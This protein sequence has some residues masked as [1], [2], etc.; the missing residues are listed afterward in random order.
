MHRSRRAPITAL[1]G[2]LALAGLAAAAGLPTYTLRLHRGKGDKATYEFTSVSTDQITG[3]GAPAGAI[4]SKAQLACAI[5]FQGASPGG[6]I[7]IQAKVKEGLVKGAVGGQS[8]TIPVKT[9]LATYVLTPRSELKQSELTTGSPP[10]ISATGTVFTA[11]DAFLPPPLPDK[12]VRVGDRWQSSARIPAPSGDPADARDVKY[13]SRVLGEMTYAGRSCLKIRTAF[14]QSQHG[15]VKAP[16]GSGSVAVA[17]QSKG[18]TT[19]VFDPKAG[20]VMKS[21]ATGTMTITRVAKTAGQQQLLKV[22]STIRTHAKM[23]EYN[24]KKIAAQ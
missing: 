5:E 1:L 4:T 18:E 8:Q 2:A 19:W 6:R 21:D 16:D 24:G 22:S 17:V 23:T 14:R 12:P 13:A 10:Q 9:S 11:D 20:L 7:V 15:T 3:P